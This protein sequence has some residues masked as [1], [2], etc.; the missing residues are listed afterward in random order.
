LASFSNGG[1]AL[2]VNVPHSTANGESK[3]IYFQVQAPAG[4]AWVGFGQGSQMAG[5][6]MFLVYAD[7]ANNVTVSPRHGQGHFE[8][9]FDPSAHITVLEGSGV[10]PDGSLIANVRCDTCLI[11]DGGSMNPNESSSKWIWAYKTGHSLGSTSMSQSISQHSEMGAFLL[12]L[13]LGQG[14]NSTN[15]FLQ[16]LTTQ[17][18]SGSAAARSV[19]VGINARTR[20]SHAAIMSLIFV[21]LFPAAALTMYVPMAQRVRYIHAPLQT[22]N[23]ILL[24][25]GL[26]TGSLL[27]HRGPGFDGYH[28]V[29]GFIIS[30]SLLLFQPT[31]GIYQHLYFRKHN[32]RSA[33][34]S[35]HRWLGRSAIILGIVNGGLG[36][37]TAGKVGSENLPR[38]AITLYGTM[39]GVALSTY[40]FIVVYLWHRSRRT[41][42]TD[43]P[44]S[45]KAAS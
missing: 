36:F 31:L 8:P 30:F 44:L 42:V 39:A 37:H 28:Q 13:T 22:I 17:S 25:A 6:N 11:W 2:S 27:A 43:P 34:G 40:T 24:V 10:Q 9:K 18:T 15:P 5:A 23:L 21:L 32:L 35:A 12:D 45:H 1:Y 33:T 3:E 41:S 26:S 16:V 7:G 4:T 38:W 19:G 29:I 20:R 14:G